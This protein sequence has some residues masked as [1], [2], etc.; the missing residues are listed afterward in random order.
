MEPEPICVNSKHSDS[1]QQTAVVTV[2]IE[3]SAFIKGAV[4]CK[5]RAGMHLVLELHHN[6]RLTEGMS[7]CSQED[8]K[9]A[10]IQSC[11]IC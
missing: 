7:N 5:G 4:T 1:P 10:T 9:P 6:L 11:D 3:R 8:T 2:T